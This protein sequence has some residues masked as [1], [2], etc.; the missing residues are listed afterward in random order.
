MS[1]ISAS[2]AYMVSEVVHVHVIENVF[3]KLSTYNALRVSKP[4]QGKTLFP[5]ERSCSWLSLRRPAF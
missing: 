5:H 3:Q 4:V 1:C 2:K